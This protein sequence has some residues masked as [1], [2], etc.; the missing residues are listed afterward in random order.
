MKSLRRE[1]ETSSRKTVGAMPPAGPDH[2][3]GQPDTPVTTEKRPVC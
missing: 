2:A 3:P 1:Q